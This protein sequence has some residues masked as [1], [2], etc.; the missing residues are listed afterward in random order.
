MSGNR[1]F[2]EHLRPS[3]VRLDKNGAAQLDDSSGIRAW[4]GRTQALRA[5]RRTRRRGW[6]TTPVW[7]VERARSLE[8]QA[9]A[10]L[11]GK[12]L[13]LVRNF[14]QQRGLSRDRAE[15]VTQGYFEGMVKRGE[16]RQLD[17]GASLGAW[18]RTGAIHHF[19]NELDKEK[20]QKRLLNSQAT[21]ELQAQLRDHGGASPERLLDRRRALLLIDRAWQ[22]LRTE[23]QRQ[24]CER[25]FDHL[26]STLLR[27][28]DDVSDAMLGQSLGY[29]KSYV[30]VARHR[31]RTSELPAALL[32]EFREHRAREKVSSATTPSRAPAPVAEEMRALL[33]AL[34]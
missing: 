27:E 31:L 30:A 8:P 3:E 23:Y 4:N 18:L 19:Y 29:S 20:A 32:A 9:I 24:G 12:Y 5:T 17:A 21:S 11:C 33:D 13:Q 25:L 22:R 2:R 7:L 26:K 34:A 15:D 16:F 28:A 14:L 6:L 1:P 10:F